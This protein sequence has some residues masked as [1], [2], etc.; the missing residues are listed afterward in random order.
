MDKWFT[1]DKLDGQ[2][3]VISEYRHWE[4]THCYLL[5][6]SERSLLIDTGLGIENIYDEVCRLTN[7]PVA[8][9]ATH[10]HW[11][12]IGGHKYFTELYVHMNELDWIKGHFPLTIE[13]VREMVLDRCDMPEG[14][15]INSYELFRGEPSRVLDDRD[16]IDLGGRKVEVLHTPGH[17]PGHMCFWEKDRGY[18][19]TGDLVYKDILFAYYP[20]TDPDAYLESLEKIVALPV[21][22]V[23]PAHHSLDIQT[24]LIRRMR[25]AL[26][27]LKEEGRLCHGIGRLDYGDWGIW[28]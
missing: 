14:F 28:L 2:T 11:D 26:R 3:Y 21:K 25:D 24:E 20:S 13:M 9:V 6:G 12:H 16:V 18:L 23:L 4:E 10:I 5:N 1:V 27:E 22:R 19:Y 15:D 17:S 7:K 8:A